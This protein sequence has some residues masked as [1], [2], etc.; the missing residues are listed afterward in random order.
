MKYL[1]KVKGVKVKNLLKKILSIALLLFLI[2][3]IVLS[4]IN[5]KCQP[6][7]WGKY[8][9]RSSVKNVIVMVPD[10]CSQ[11]IQTL[12]R[13]KKGEA[14][15]LDSILVGAV[16][17]YMANSIITE[18][19]AAVTAFATGYKTT[20]GFLNVGPRTEDIL[21]T[22]RH[23]GSEMQYRPLATVLEGARL[24]NKSTGIVATSII[25]HATPAGFACHIHDRN[26][27]NEI[28]EQMVYENID[29]AF[30]GG[31]QYLLP[32]SETGK[33]TDNENL[34]TV[35]NN[36]GYQIVENKKEMEVITSG[37]V[38]GLFAE[39]HMEPDINRKEFL[40]NQPSL[41]EMTAKAI[42]LLSRNKDG[43]FLMVE[44][45]QI[46]WAG[47]ANDPIFMVTDFL[48]FDEAVKVAFDFARRD[49]NTLLLVFPDHDCGGLSIGNGTT[50]I[51]SSEMK[52]EDLV[53]P[54]KEMKVTAGFIEYQI[55]TDHS[56]AKIS[57]EISKWWGIDITE[58]DYKEIKE[59][60]DNGAP[61]TYSI[62][63]I[64]SK[65]HTVIGWTSHG[66]TGEDV[67]LWAYGPNRPV[68]LYDNT[69]LAKIIAQALG[70]NLDSINR[71]LFAEVGE[72]FA[73]YE[74]DKTDT[75]NP[76]LKINNIELPI[77]K[78]LLITAG[79]T[80]ELNGIVVYAPNTNKVYI[81]R[82]AIS[83]IEKL[84]K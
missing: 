34:L 6:C 63:E 19:S 26:K 84:S 37:K 38:W 70:F 56:Y 5:K 60:M 61:L 28:T 66:H 75:T 62:G 76:V 65:N 69:E 55:G 53:V 16:K 50:R 68:G 1:P 33:R 11:S 52:V 41:A 67:P 44:G 45:S 10:G 77:N 57:K 14:L 22:F 82:E 17:T 43:F 27:Y 59:L 51:P 73:N 8:F 49:K 7:K 3:I 32:K 42:E 80:Y 21:T 46:D 71:E 72:V 2:F 79:R 58:N 12:A 78:N 30:G 15:A 40:S 47:H 20:G 39:G 36:K 35:L 23:P 9:P 64:I 31:K 48:A 29:V 83:L 13:W 54:L 74:L 24:K 81:P 25:C 18:S 4:V